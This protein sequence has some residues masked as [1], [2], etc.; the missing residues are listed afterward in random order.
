MNRDTQ[1][2]MCLDAVSVTKVFPQKFELKQKPYEFG[3]CGKCFAREDYVK[4][5]MKTHGAVPNLLP[6]LNE[7]LYQMCCD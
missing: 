6:S 5:H 2:P 3:L 1:V 7:S 4:I